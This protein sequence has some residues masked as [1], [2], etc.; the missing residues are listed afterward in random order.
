MPAA[1]SLQCHFTSSV[2]LTLFPGGHCSTSQIV[3]DRHLQYILPLYFYLILKTPLV[4][5]FSKV[6]KYLAELRRQS[7]SVSG[8]WCWFPL[9][10]AP[11]P[12][13]TGNEWLLIGAIFHW[14]CFFDL[15]LTYILAYKARHCVSLNESLCSRISYS[16]WSPVFHCQSQQSS[17]GLLLALILHAS[18]A[19]FNKEWGRNLSELHSDWKAWWPCWVSLSRSSLHLIWLWQSRADNIQFPI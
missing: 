16:P 8:S 17:S 19:T 4:S 6:E 7:K 9:T 18:L 10:E 2:W 1:S 14:L 11:T 5:L 12:R 13:V 15:H 3:S